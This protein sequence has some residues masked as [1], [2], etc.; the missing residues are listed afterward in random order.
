VYK[1][2]RGFLARSAR[3]VGYSQPPHFARTFLHR[4]GILPST[5]RAEYAVG[6]NPQS[7]EPRVRASRLLNRS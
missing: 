5:F 2:V 6:F 4:F 1:N 3:L 7:G